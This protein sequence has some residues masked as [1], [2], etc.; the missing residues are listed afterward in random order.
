MEA[1]SGRS[2][3]R[4]RGSITAP[5]R[6]WAPGQVL[7]HQCYVVTLCK[8]AYF[9]TLLQHDNSD[10]SSFLLLKLLEPDGCT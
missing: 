9:S 6:T 3:L 7:V 1:Q 2:S 4:A 5:E 10:L 8:L